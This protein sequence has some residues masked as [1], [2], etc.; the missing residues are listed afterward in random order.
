M[1]LSEKMAEGLTGY[2]TYKCNQMAIQVGASQDTVNVR[3][4]LGLKLNVFF[5]H[6]TNVHLLGSVSAGKVTSDV[7]VI[8]TNDA[9]NDIS[10][11]DAFGAL[12]RNKSA[13]ILHHEIYSQ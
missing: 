12:R 1:I 7:H 4:Y 8:V 3:R 5:L 9:C 10:R 6:E 13:R 2:C 11:R